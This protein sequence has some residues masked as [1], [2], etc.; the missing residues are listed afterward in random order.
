MKWKQQYLDGKPFQPTKAMERGTEIHKKIENFYRDVKIRDNKV[1]NDD[2]DLK[3]FVEFENSRLGDAQM[4]YFKPLHQEMK[5][6]DPKTRLRGVIDAV[7]KNPKDD[8]IIVIDWKTGLYRPWK[9]NDYRFELAIYKSL[10]DSRQTDKVKYWGIFFTD[11]GKLFFE[12][13]KDNVVDDALKIVV[14]V[15]EEMAS[16]VYPCKCGYCKEV[17]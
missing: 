1:I 14:D 13:A 5:L 8:G 12:E 4:K 11:A 15:R 17:K 7:Y 10:Y 2:K 6:V 16:G 9:I 3:K